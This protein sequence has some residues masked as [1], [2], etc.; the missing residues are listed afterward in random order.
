F[1]RPSPSPSQG[2]SYLSRHS[3]MSEAALAKIFPQLPAWPA[4]CDLFDFAG[5]TQDETAQWLRWN[6][7]IGH[8]SMVLLKV[9]RASMHHAL[10]VRVPL[11]D[12]EVIET[13]T[14]V[15]WRSC[16]DLSARIGKIPL[17]RSLRRHASRDTREKRGFGVPIGAW[18]RGPLR[19]RFE[20]SVLGRTELLG[21]PVDRQA[22]REMFMHHLE[23]RGRHIGGLYTLLGAALWEDRHAR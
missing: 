11:L 18:L 16:L 5:G 22:M 2:A 4:G 17:R 1:D 14:R 15:D 3:S 9:D 10:E 23:G 6:E 8:L 12:K 7:F 19:E 13:A 21:M 20:S